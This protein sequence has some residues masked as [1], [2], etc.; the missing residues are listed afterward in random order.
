MGEEKK[1]LPIDL[2]KLHEN[3]S[4]GIRAERKRL[5]KM[6]K[7]HNVKKGEYVEDVVSDRHL[8]D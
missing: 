4:R 6:P 7:K 3:V 8:E 1:K 5:K 2:G